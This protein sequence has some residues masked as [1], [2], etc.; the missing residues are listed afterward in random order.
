MKHDTLVIL[1][2]TG[3]L[4]KRLLMPA[5][6]RLHRLGLTPDLNIVGYAM[7]K[8]SR[9]RFE[10]HIH[11]AIKSFAP[12]FSAKDW[13][14]FRKHLDYVGGKLE[15]GDLRN[16]KK[17]I[18]ARTLFYMALPPALF[19]EASQALGEAGFAKAPRGG[20]RRVVVE[21]PFGHDLGSAQELR[22][23]MHIH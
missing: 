2:A 11:K 23:Q 22:K 6:Y 20:W 18:G 19:G 9:D 21:K 5:L 7:Q 12:D 8:W 16:L 10:K 15:V 17:K 1:G 13:N 4:T 14:S 3:D